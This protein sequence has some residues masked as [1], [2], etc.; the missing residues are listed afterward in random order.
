MN[1][2]DDARSVASSK[3]TRSLRSGFYNSSLTMAS[4]RYVPDDAT[5]THTFS[6]SM[7]RFDTCI[8]GQQV[9]QPQQKHTVLSRVV[10]KRLLFG[11]VLP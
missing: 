7:G 10:F 8:L 1:E 3:Y 9:I 5:S 6:T 11:V 2:E 4:G